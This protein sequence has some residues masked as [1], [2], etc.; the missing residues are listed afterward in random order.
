MINDL[1]PK[2]VDVFKLILIISG[3]NSVLSQRPN[4]VVIVADDLGW[5]DVG[6]RSVQLLTPNIDTLAADGIVLNKY[7]TSPVC[8]PSRSALLSAV[9]PI[10]TG[11]QNYVILTAHP[12]GMPL[13]VKLLP[14]HLKDLG[15]MTHAVGRPSIWKYADTLLTHWFQANGI[16]VS[17]DTNTLPLFGASIHTSATGRGPRTTSITRHSKTNTIGV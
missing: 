9:H 5:S 3:T 2:I 14:E 10:H 4:I 6:F 11:L 16:W 12:Y 8:S 15:Y 13:D 1:N 17:S 7:Y